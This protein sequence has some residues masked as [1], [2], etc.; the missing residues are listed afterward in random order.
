VLIRHLAYFVTLARVKHYARAADACNIAQPTLSAA[1]RKLE[2]DLQVHLVVRGHR[3]IGLTQ[4]GE[5]V[6]QWGQR[7][8]VD[9]ASLRE[10]LSG[11]HRGLTGTLRLGVIPAAMPAVAFLTALFS[12]SHPVVS[13]DIQSM[14]SRAIQ[15]GIDSF[16]IECGLTYLDNEPLENV[17]QVPLYRERYVFITKRGNRYADRQSLT[18][19]EA[20]QERLCLPNEDMQN[21]RIIDKIAASAGLRISASVVTNSFAGVCSHLI[22]GDWSSIV[23]HMFPIVLGRSSDFVTIPL[24][25]P[26]ATQSIGLVI[27]S[28]DPLSPIAGAL[29]ATAL[30]VNFDQ[31]LEADGAV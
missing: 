18:W 15:R 27:S 4:D 9:Y 6:L 19:A 10:G 23:P 24:I 5:K 13:I 11:S 17:R 31:E 3:F 21:R 22:Q 7:I 16:E 1:I 8:L 20:V 29:M 25:E 30:N 12:A 28:R 26:I 14:T 2:E